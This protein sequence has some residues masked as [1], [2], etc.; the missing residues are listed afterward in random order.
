VSYQSRQGKL[1]LFYDQLQPRES[2]LVLDVG[3][4]PVHWSRAAGAPVV[5]NFLEASYP[6]PERI[7]ALSIDPLVEFKKSY[8]KMPTVQGSGCALPFADASFDLVFSNAVIEHVGDRSWQ[9]KL[10]RECL[11]V[12]R[13]AV[14][15]AAPNRL[16]PYDTHVG[17]PL[18]HYFPR[19]VWKRLGTEPG[20]HLLTPMDLVRLFPAWSKPVLLGSSY[21]PSVVVIARPKP[22]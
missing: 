6:W 1:K 8:P 21:A 19:A 22:R 13:R 18:V 15:I 9:A 7:V 20:L 2:D 16:F 11:R 4:T 14:F 12:A 3:V 17:L 10:V 5:E